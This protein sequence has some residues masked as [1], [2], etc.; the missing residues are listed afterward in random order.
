MNKEYLIECI[1]TE[2]ESS[3]FDFKKDGECITFEVQNGERRIKIGPDVDIVLKML[4]QLKE[5]FL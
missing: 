1:E 4:N 5:E 3:N 2:I